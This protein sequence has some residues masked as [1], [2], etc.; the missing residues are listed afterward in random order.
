MVDFAKIEKK[1]QRR[2]YKEKIFDAKPDSKRKK[3]FMAVPYPYA[4]G[5][6]HIGH[7]RTYTVADT[8]SRFKRLQGYNVLFPIAWHVTGTPVLA[9]AQQIKSKDPKALDQYKYYIK[10]H[11]KD[12]NKISKILK[13]FEEPENVMKYFSKTMVNDFKL[14]GYSMDFSRQ[15]TTT[16]KDYN[17]FIEWQFTHL[18]DKKYLTQG[19]FPILYS[20]EDQNAVGTDDIKDGDTNPVEISEFT[21]IKFRFKNEQNKY[22]VASTLRPET[23]FGLTNLWINPKENYVNLKVGN[24]EWIVSKEAA[25]KL[26]YQKLKIDS[27]TKVDVDDIIDQ[28]V[29]TP[30]TNKK[31]PILPASFVDGEV[32]TGV[33]Y[34]V[35]ASA[36]FDF[37]GL[38]DLQRAG[39]YKSIKPIPIIKMEGYT[40][41]PAKELSEKN[42]IQDQSET[43]AIDKI[44]KEIYAAEFHKGIMNENCMDFSGM[45]VSEAKPIV[46][47]RLLTDDNGFTFYETSRKAT[48]RSKSKVSV[49][50]LSGQWFLHYGN[51]KWKNGTRDA[52]K[53]I[54]IIPEHYRKLFDNTIEW[55]D[56]KPVAR[57]RGLGTQLPF[58]KQWIIESLSDS[59]I[60]MALYTVINTIRENKIKPNQLT[61]DFWDYVFLGKGSDKGISKT[62]GISTKLLNS[63]KS[64]FEYWYPLDQRHT[65]IHHLSNHLTMMIFNHEAIFGAKKVPKK[66]TLNDM[67]I[68]EGKK[69]SKSLGNVIPIAQVQDKYFIDLFR[70][71]CIYAAELSSQLDWREKDVQALSTKLNQFYELMNKVSK[72]KPEKA[73]TTWLESRFQTNLEKAQ[74]SLE[75]DNPRHYFQAMFYDM[76]NDVQYFIRRNNGSL[77]GIE[78]ITKDWIVSVSPAIPHIAEE[79]WEKFKGKG[80]VST[81]TWPKFNK[82]KINK[83][84]EEAE[85]T[86]QKTM[87][88]INQILQITNKKSAKNIYI[89]VIPP[90]LKKYEEAESFLAGIFN[91]NVK[92]FASNDK[93]KIDPD[94]KASKAKFGKPGIYLN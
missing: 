80:F 77:D 53:K 60:Y 81:S 87:S 82:N 43:D 78:K 41:M 69:M 79:L 54:E 11:E 23:L 38:R 56:K 26:K 57:K 8:I 65:G 88:D 17:K 31:V 12:S 4:S 9:V 46:I 73:D 51:E 50:V 20:V 84:V 93:K 63:M 2:W 66:I 62:T 15:F 70:A 27:A 71:Y 36:P 30:I 1:W 49:A 37:I 28:E 16:D 94:N 72:N 76:M 14:A 90:E 18:N 91:T 89:Y 6:L 35:P 61:I 25:E 47:E 42:D 52:F 29:I 83:E 58:D 5:P 21:T 40:D 7:G 86:I 19:D 64:E 13:S 92:I 44:T 55:L 3:Y 10:Y 32:G 85:K 45:K 59:T 68:R 22:L 24:E 74:T 39:L 34:S 75:N 48:T 67:L 33:V